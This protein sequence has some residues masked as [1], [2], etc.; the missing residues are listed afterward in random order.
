MGKFKNVELAKE[1]V[2]KYSEDYVVVFTGT[3]DRYPETT[4]EFV[5]EVLP[6]QRYKWITVPGDGE[7]GLYIPANTDAE[8]EAEILAQWEYW[9]AEGICLPHLVVGD[10]DDDSNSLTVEIQEGFMVAYFVLEGSDPMVD[11]EEQV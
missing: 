10:I 7:P 5:K 8:V 3:H 4:E 2:S 11:E 1:K 9:L 6:G